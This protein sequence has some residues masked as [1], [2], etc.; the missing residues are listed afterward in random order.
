MSPA[1]VR[2][3]LLTNLMSAF[4]Y[5]VIALTSAALRLLTLSWQLPSWPD[6]HFYVVLIH[7]GWSDCQILFHRGSFWSSIGAEERPRR[8]WRSACSSVPRWGRSWI[9]PCMDPRN[10]IGD[11]HVPALLPL[12]AQRA[13]VA[14][15]YLTGGVLGDLDGAPAAGFAV[16]GIA[17]HVH[18]GQKH[19]STY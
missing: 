6:Q 10:I 5:H 14:F 16:D 12:V 9:T 13:L 17:W 11:F 2:A 19:E 4:S 18:Q 15:A 7:Y 8:H 1:Q 3:N